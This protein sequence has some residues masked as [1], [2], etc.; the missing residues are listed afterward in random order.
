MSN[1]TITESTKHED[2]SGNGNGSL[3]SST[4]EDF[5]QQKVTEKRLRLEDDAGL[6]TAT[7][8]HFRRPVEHPFTSDQRDT[9]TVLF[10]GLTWRHERLIE[11]ALAA[12]DYTLKAIPTPDVKAFQL[13]K[14][15]G[16]NAQCN[17]TYFT[18]GNLVQY[19]QGLEEKGLSRKDIIDN[20]VFMTAGACGPC[21][22]GL[23]EA[24]YRLAL[25]NSGFDG[26]RVILFGLEGGLDQTETAYEPGLEMNLDFFLA[27]LNAMMI[28]DELFQLGYQVRPYE[29]VQGSTDAAMQEAIQDL[30]DTLRGTEKVELKGIW[31][32]LITDT[33]FESLT[34]YGIK[35]IHQLK[36]QDL[37]QALDLVQRK[38]AEI[39][40]DRFRVRPIIKIVGEFWAHTTEGDGNFNIFPFLEAEGAEVHVDRTVGT[41]VL[42]MLH[43]YKALA[44]ENKGLVEGQ[45]PPPSWRLDKRF[46]NG[47]KSRI[48]IGVLSAAEGIY[49]RES[50]RV[51]EALGGT[52]H[53]S[54]DQ[55]ELDKLASPFYNW[56]AGAGESHMEVGEN[57][58]YH[59]HHLCHMILS[60]KPFGCMP[61]AQSDAVQ[62]AVVEHFRDMIYLAVETSGEG[63]VNAHSRV[64]MG[65]GNARIKAKQEFKEAVAR[66][67]RSLEELKSFVDDH[68][69]L[70]S[71]MYH[72]PH[73]EGVVGK[74]ANF[75]LHV[76]ELMAG[77]GQMKHP[78][79]VAES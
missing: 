75:A 38:F 69:E 17:P 57:I 65:L 33:K 45:A 26:F 4:I 60:L 71:S 1:E 44:K 48:K 6:D 11:G 43:Q 32:K 12:L 58:Y 23:Y 49:K 20:Y 9:T 63:E 66:T 61:S 28:G 72:V 39:E 76:G 30:H 68:P 64:Q 36:R 51:R 21:R 67:G 47:L 24:E 15:Y 13:G 37:P 46:A 2:N 18:V 73:S 34:N 56:R 22:F 70:K 74:A 5:I 77:N 59:T 54:A 16:N 53:K 25:R 50:N 62:A 8:N 41:R 40:I 3:S 10:G 78:H 79:V 7:V 27:I 19:L 31:K 42:Y 55:Y 52:L 35:F 14:E 29:I